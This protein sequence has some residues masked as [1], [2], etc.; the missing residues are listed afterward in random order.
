MQSTHIF[1][2]VAGVTAL[3]LSGLLLTACSDK[4]VPKSQQIEAPVTVMATQCRTAPVVFSAAGNVVADPRVSL[5]SRFSAYVRAVHFKEGAAVKAGDVVVELDDRDIVAAQKAAYG[6]VKAAQAAARDAAMDYDKY[7]ALY[8]EGLISNHAW[9]K[10]R[11]KNEAAE[12]DLKEAQALY[13]AAIV[14]QDYLTVRT[15]VSGHVVSVLKDAGDMALPGLPIVV[16]DADADPKIEFQIPEEVRSQWAVGKVV[17]VVVEGVEGDRTAVVEQLSE[18]ADRRIRSYFARARFTESASIRPGM[19]GR[20]TAVV[21]EGTRPAVPVS[22]LT[23]RGGLTGVFVVDQKRALFHW[24]KLG[25][26]MADVVEVLAGLQGQEMVVD[27]P[28]P[29]LY[30]GVP[31]RLAGEHE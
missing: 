25:T 3:V 13:E 28:S 11:L 8:K 2:L 30:D 12:S 17:S 14:Q 10:A 18:S 4:T 7:S 15:P 29:L 21:N 20:I 5:T 19:Y 24:L 6:K 23:D 16:V 1:S 9:R 27:R 31:V 22:A 26:R